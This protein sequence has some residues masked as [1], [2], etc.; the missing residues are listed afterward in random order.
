MRRSRS[1]SRDLCVGNGRILL[2]PQL[3]VRFSRRVT[4][5]NRCVRFSTLLV[6]GDGVEVRGSGATMNVRR[7][8]TGVVILPLG[9]TITAPTITTSRG[10]L[11]VRHLL[12]RAVVR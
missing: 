12:R 6:D 2:G 5:F 10:G 1:S 8:S 11:R 9:R 3:P 4:L 7:G